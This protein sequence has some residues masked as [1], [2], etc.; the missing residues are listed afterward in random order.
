MNFSMLKYPTALVPIGLSL[1]SLALVFGFIAV[2]GMP[3]AAAPPHDEGA[4]AHLWQLLIL[5]HG[6]AILV[7]LAKWAPRDIKAAM[8]VLAVQVVA[9]GAAL[10]PVWIIGL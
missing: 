9:L 6:P 7:F 2:Y 3:D 4:A 1:A 8:T 5:A 10:A